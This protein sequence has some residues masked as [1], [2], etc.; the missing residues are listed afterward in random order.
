MRRAPGSRAPCQAEL[1]RPLAVIADLQGPKLR[2]GELA[3]P[4]LLATGD[5]VVIAGEDVAQPGDLPVAP[6]VIGQV[7]VRPA[8]T[9]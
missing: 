7:L 1:R 8:T 3:A 2:I 6:S 5:L 4:R 9:C